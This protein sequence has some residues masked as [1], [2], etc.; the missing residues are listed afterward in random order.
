MKVTAHIAHYAVSAGLLAAKELPRR[1]KFADWGDATG[2][3]GKRIR[4]NSLSV[5]SIPIQQAKNGWDRISLDYEHNTLKGTPEFER[6]REPRAIAAHGRVDIV[7]G[8]GL[9]LDDLVWTPHGVT[10]AREY[11]DLSPA[12]LQTADDTIVGVHSVALCRHGV[13]DGLRAY[14]VELP[15][16]GASNMDWKKWLADLCGMPED[17]ADADLKKGFMAKVSALCAEAIAPVVAV[18]E[19]LK[20]KLTALSAGD[21]AQTI[22]ALSADVT[23]LKTEIVDLKSGIERR[24]RSDIVRQAALDGKVI[25]LS[26][27]QL[28]VTPVAT[29]RDMAAKLAVTV[30]M[31]QRTPERINALSADAA[32]STALETVA[33]ACGV[34]PKTVK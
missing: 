27:E 28:D 34:D 4:V 19:D 1:M 9:Y 24:D 33:R 7:P 29:L 22:T 8:D 26:A 3:G 17:T 32:V 11:C 2:V 16:E 18:A 15:D 25:P 12:P 21:P 31:E 10:Y 13:I 14:S 5:A 20:T 23:G 30:P 6:T